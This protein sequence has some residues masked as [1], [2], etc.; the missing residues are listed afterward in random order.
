MLFRVQAPE[1][2]SRP[3]PLIHMSKAETNLRS[4]SEILNVFRFPLDGMMNEC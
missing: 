3:T 2:T 1:E 4:L